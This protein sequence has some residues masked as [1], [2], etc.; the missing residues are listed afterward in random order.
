MVLVSATKAKSLDLPWTA[1]HILHGTILKSSQPW[2]R[3]WGRILMPT[4]IVGHSSVFSSY[5]RLFLSIAQHLRYSTS[6]SDSKA[7]CLN[8][9]PCHKGSVWRVELPTLHAARSLARC[10]VEIAFRVRLWR[11]IQK[12][13]QAVSRLNVFGK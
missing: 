12:A 7:C 5:L 4:G 1:K 6:L 9:F 8:G 11:L 10:V 3:S 2:L 13:M